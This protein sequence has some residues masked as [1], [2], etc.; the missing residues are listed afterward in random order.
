LVWHNGG[1]NG[2]RS[3][4]GFYSKSRI[5][6][7]VLSNA[8]TTAGVDDIGKHLLNARAPLL[9]QSAFQPPN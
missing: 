8:Q 9:P 2:Y 7:V 6:V 3:F 1:T 4:V 5:G